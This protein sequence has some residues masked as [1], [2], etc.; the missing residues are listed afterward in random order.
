MRME[1]RGVVANSL[2]GVVMVVATNVFSCRTPLH[3]DTCVLIMMPL[4]LPLPSL[5][6]MLS[7]SLG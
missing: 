1:D 7:G 4:L 5:L 6:D 2:G 3:W